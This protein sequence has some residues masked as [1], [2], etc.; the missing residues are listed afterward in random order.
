MAVLYGVFLYM[1]ITSLAGV[2]F[3]ERILILFMPSNDSFF[4]PLLTS[5]NIGNVYSYLGKY[6]Q[7]LEQYKK[8]LKIR[9]AYFF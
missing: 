4:I 7:A 9:I 1:G 3:V 6:H 8:A 2:Q 5:F